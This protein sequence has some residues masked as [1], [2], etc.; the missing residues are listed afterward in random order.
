VEAGKVSVNG[1]P[2]RNPEARVDPAR[3]R[4]AVDGKAVR[5]AARVYLALHKPHGLVTTTAD[6][7][8][9]DTVYVCLE[10]LDLPRVSPVGRLDMDSEGL[11]LFTNDTRWAQRVVD[12]QAGVDKTYEVLVSGAAGE[13]L[14]GALTTDTR[15]AKGVVPGAKSARRIRRERDDTWV[16]LVLDEGRNR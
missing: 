4:I 14:L 7:R 11:L 1:Q 13:D 6:E 10:G 12:P 2:V 8:G 9:R 16:E 15:D 3:D 5:G